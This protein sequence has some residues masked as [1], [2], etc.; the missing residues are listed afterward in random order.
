LRLVHTKDTE[1]LTPG[2]QG[3]EVPVARQRFLPLIGIGERTGK[4]HQRKRVRLVEGLEEPAPAVRCRR[5]HPAS[6]VLEKRLEETRQLAAERV[7]VRRVPERLE[8]GHELFELCPSSLRL[9]R[10][11]RV[12][13]RRC[14]HFET[15]A[16]EVDGVGNHEHDEARD[17]IDVVGAGQALGGAE[18]G[19]ERL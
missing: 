7:S 8:R 13:T 1:H 12:P 16:P 2:P 3:N 17:Q 18:E 19:P 14:D 9:L 11:P 6:P 10:L 4:I 5:G 15:P